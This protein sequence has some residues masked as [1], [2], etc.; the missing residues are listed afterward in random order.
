[1]REKSH[2]SAA[3][4]SGAESSDSELSHVEKEIEN[5]STKLSGV[6]Y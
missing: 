5:C 4:Y 6:V 1:M 2:Q 3:D